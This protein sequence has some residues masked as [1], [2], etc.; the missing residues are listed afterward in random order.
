T[1][2]VGDFASDQE[3]GEAP[4][5]IEREDGSLLV[6]GSLSADGLSDRLGL[7]YDEDR[8]FA[9]AAGFVLSVLRKLPEEGEHFVE[10]GWRFEVVDMDGRRIDKLLVSREGPAP[11]AD[12][13]G[14]D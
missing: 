12:E 7:A 8:E 6:S 9:T 10:Q 2:L 13:F 3:H 11:E 4:G 1:A 14:E 5:V